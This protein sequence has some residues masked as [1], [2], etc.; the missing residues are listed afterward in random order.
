MM[1][2]EICSALLDEHYFHIEHD[3][4]LDVY[5]FPKKLTTAYALL[6]AR[7]GSVDHAVRLD[8]GSILEFPDGVAH[9]LEHKLF[10][11]EDGS[12]SFSTFSALGADANAYTSYQ[13]TAYL[14]GCTEHFEES[15]CELLRFVT[16]P[17]FTEESVARERGIIAEE[18]RM[19]DDSPWDR[20]LRRLLSALYRTHPVRKNIC[21]SAASIQRITPEL[22]YRAHALFYHPRNMALVVCGDVTEEQVL[23][24]V[25]Q[26]LG[27]TSAP[28]RAPDRIVP[29]DEKCVF[30]ARTSCKM[31][32]SKPIFSIGIKDP[33]VLSDPKTRLRRDAAMTLLDEVLF[34]RSGEL[35]NS[36]FEQGL[37]TSAFYA[38][39]SCT[40]RFAYHCISG[41]S[42]TPE[43]VLARVRD[44]I[45]RVQ[46]EGIDR[47]VLER[48][49]RVL[50][51]DEIRAF[52]STEEIANRLLS[53]VFDDAEIFSYPT[54]LQEISYEEVTELLHSVF[55]DEYFT[56][57]T[58]EPL[59][60]SDEKENT[61]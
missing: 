48:H 27:K 8:D 34:S 45:A 40:D 61:K 60:K 21:G 54:L 24:A 36:L 49:R 10:E 57:S 38:G 7:Y 44:Y 18:I 25:D 29:E 12:D 13:R 47:E 19:Y 33:V 14:F 26:V 52:D 41:E 30:A 42:D 53:F 5:V 11:N 17:H 31:Q 39:Y 2:T 37:I 3:C 16:H 59:E 51:A 20:C 46:R 58:V 28:Y 55:R 22:L 15:L 56:L 4:G 23:G 50:Y 32:V 6:S 9:F 35:Y 43:E 1:R